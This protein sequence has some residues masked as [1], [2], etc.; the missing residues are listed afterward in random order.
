MKEGV[1]RRYPLFAGE[2][3]DR[4]RGRHRAQIVRRHLAGVG[5]ADLTTKNYTRCLTKPVEKFDNQGYERRCRDTVQRHPKASEGSGYLILL[6]GASSGDT[7]ARQAHRKTAGMPFLDPGKLQ[8]I[9]RE[10]GAR[11]PGGDRQYRS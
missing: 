5:G 10:T 9:T 2:V 3:D 4:A 11:D 7:M 8:Y 6:K 1:W